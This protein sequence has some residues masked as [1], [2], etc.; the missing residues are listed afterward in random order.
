MAP[1]CAALVAAKHELAVE[2]QRNVSESERRLAAQREADLKAVRY[3]F[4][5][6]ERRVNFALV[7]SA[8]GQGGE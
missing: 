8:R 7:A 3:A 1:R 2:G 6:M 5:R 4:E